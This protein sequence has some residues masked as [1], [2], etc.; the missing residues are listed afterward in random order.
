MINVQYIPYQSIDFIK[1]DR[2]IE[3]AANGNVYACSFYLNAMAKNWDALVLNDYE[4]VMPLTWNKKYGISYLYQ[5]F[6]CAALGVFGNDITKQLFENFL[7]SIPEKFSYCDI[8]CNASNYFDIEGINIY[9]RINYVLPINQTYEQL[10]TQFRDNIKRNIKKAAQLNCVIKTNI[11]VD[12]VIELAKE[13]SVNFSPVKDEDYSR[14]KKVYQ[15]LVSENKAITYGVYT[16]TNELVASCVFFFSHKRAYYILVGNHPNGKTI[17]ASHAIINAF[18]KDHAEQ[19]LVL[20][21][22]GSDIKNL[23]FFY[24]S[25]GATEEKYIGLKYNR[26]PFWMKWFKK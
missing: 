26:L 16:S 13:Q 14:F 25:F 18:I 11:P 9:Q 6:F 17:G 20:D 15:L 2:C 3:N 19:D 10:Y 7:T 24:S 5:P 1:W 23:A 8:Y 12:A 22:E 4:A 21:F